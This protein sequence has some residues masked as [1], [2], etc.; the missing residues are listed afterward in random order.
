MS[1]YFDNK[2]A[3]LEPK[4]TQYGSNMLMTNVTKPRK[5]KLVNIDT[6]FIDIDQIDTFTL[7]L[8]ERLT[9]VTSI[10]AVHIE[11]PMSFFNISENIGNN[12]FYVRNINENSQFMITLPDGFYSPKSNLIFDGIPDDIS[13]K[14]DNNYNVLIAN[15]SQSFY[16]V[17]FETGYFDKST[18]K[19]RFG[20]L[21][22][23]RKQL[24]TLEPGNY[25]KS[26]SLLNLNPVRYIYLVVDEFSNS[27]QNS[28]FSCF[29]DSMM[30]KK[31]L[32]KIIINSTYNFGDVLSGNKHNA[33]LNS[34]KRIYCGKIDI[35]R[36]NLQLVNEMGISL[37]LNGLDFSF[38]LNIEHE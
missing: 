11:I 24:Y 9:E 38:L 33:I 37:D 30:N 15:N 19:S 2:T 20:W 32:A 34:D 4:V 10:E 27:F 8:P 12:F 26:E 18:I 29:S 36:L 35:Q 5:N 3:F 1:N 7:S 6:R 25:L 28:F 14:I 23:F 21:L 17:D 16:V 31:I 13:I 22:G